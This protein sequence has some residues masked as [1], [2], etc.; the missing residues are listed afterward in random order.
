[1]EQ[2]VMNRENKDKMRRKKKKKTEEQRG[3]V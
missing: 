3:A 1:M 2:S